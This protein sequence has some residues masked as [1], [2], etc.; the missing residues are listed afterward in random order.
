MMRS[1][2]CL[3]ISIV[4]MVPASVPEGDDAIEQGIAA[5]E[6]EDYGQAYELLKPE[7]DG[8]NA[9]AQNLIGQAYGF[10]L[11]VQQDL[12]RAVTY[13]RKAA[14]Q[15]HAGAQE[16]MGY[17]YYEGIVVEQDYAR[18]T[19]WYE[20]AA[21]SGRPSAQ[22]SMGLRYKNGEGVERDYGKAAQWFRRSAEQGDAR[23]ALELAELYFRGF[24]GV[25]RDRRRALKWFYGAAHGGEAYAQYS[26][27]SLH[28]QGFGAPADTEIALTWALIAGNNGHSVSASAW[29]SASQRMDA[30]T[31]QR[32]E[33]RV[34]AGAKPILE[35][36][37]E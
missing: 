26:L 19:E 33:A 9:E 5:L 1:L 12:D 37:F 25:E 7:A 18:A 17:A 22:R 13:S 27:Y 2:S 11:G 31:V 8:G 4:L 32:I 28:F 35:K 15:G 10:G 34:E 3:A 14:D 29:E 30:A 16:T 24:D 20:R 36:A 6:A 21:R 23:G